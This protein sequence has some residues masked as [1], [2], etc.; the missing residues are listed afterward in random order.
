MPSPLRS[1]RPTACVLKTFCVRPTAS[2]ASSKVPSPLLRKK[3]FGP[4]RQPTTQVGMA[5][6]VEVAPGGAGRPAGELRQ[7]AGLGGHVGELALA[8]VVEQLAAARLRHEQVGVAVAVEVAERP[9]RPCRACSAMPRVLRLDEALA[10]VSAGRA[11]AGAGAVEEVG[12][13]VAVDVARRSSV[14]PLTSAA[15]AR[16]GRGRPA[17]DTSSNASPSAGGPAAGRRRSRTPSR[18]PPGTIFSSSVVLAGL[19]LER[20]RG[21]GPARRRAGRSRRGSSRR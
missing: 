7:V 8:V 11:D 15:D 14:S 19:E 17:S 16:P 2:V 13:A 21:P 6:V 4:R 1:T 20:Q 5:V 10:G 18:R 12:P 9:G 3:R